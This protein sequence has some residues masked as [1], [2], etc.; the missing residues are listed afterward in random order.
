MGGC[1]RLI[2]QIHTFLYAIALIL[3]LKVTDV[4]VVPGLSK[5]GLSTLNGWFRNL[6]HYNDIGYNKFWYYLTEVLGV[7]IVC[8]VCFLVRAIFPRDDQ[9]RRIRRRWSR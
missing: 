8:S 7:Y 9:V 4:A 5:V 6:W 2:I 3:A 1:S